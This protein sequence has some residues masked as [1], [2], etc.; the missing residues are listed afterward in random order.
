MLKFHDCV[1]HCFPSVGGR[2][3]HVNV[4]SVVMMRAAAE[5]GWDFTRMQVCAV[6]NVFVQKAFSPAHFLDH[7]QFDC[8][9]LE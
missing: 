2:A 4:A 7:T 6:R 8:G 9:K 1:P 5:T 3:R